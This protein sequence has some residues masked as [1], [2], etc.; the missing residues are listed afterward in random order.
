MLDFDRK[1]PDMTYGSWLWQKNNAKLTQRR[2]MDGMKR[3][4]T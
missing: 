4:L 2:K 1:L 3:R